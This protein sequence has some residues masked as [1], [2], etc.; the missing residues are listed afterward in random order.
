MPMTVIVPEA[1]SQQSMDILLLS[2]I[3]AVVLAQSLK[4]IVEAMTVTLW[5]LFLQCLFFE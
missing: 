3:V 5:W 4:N 1:L 2:H